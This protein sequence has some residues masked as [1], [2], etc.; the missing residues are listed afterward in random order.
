MLSTHPRILV[1]D[2]DPGFLASVSE[3]LAGLG[4]E[5]V[6]AESGAELVEQLAD[7]G[8]FAL[9][10]TDVAM[11]WMSGLQ[12]MHSARAIGLG[13]PIIVMTALTDER[14]AAQVQVL[15]VNAILLRKPFELEDLES[16]VERLLSSEPGRRGAS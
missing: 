6:L 10:I 1:A 12:A 4:A 3:A 2:D 15:G 11:P 9:V 16:A 5:V 7:Q 14:I 8:P 13:V